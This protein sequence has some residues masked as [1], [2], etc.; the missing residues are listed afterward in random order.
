MAGL[1]RGSP[2]A[3]FACTAFFRSCSTAVPG[4]TLGGVLIFI[5]LACIL[6]V[7]SATLSSRIPVGES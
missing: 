3:M 6:V 1:I 5:V 7:V 4:L 2:E